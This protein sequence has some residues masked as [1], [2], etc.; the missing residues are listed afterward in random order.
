MLELSAIDP[1]NGKSVPGWPELVRTSELGTIDDQRQGLVGSS[2]L[3]R[4][5]FGALIR[6]V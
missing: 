2:W 1:P 4:M 6:T 3:V 5:T